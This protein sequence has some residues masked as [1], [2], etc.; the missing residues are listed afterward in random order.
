[1]FTIKFSRLKVFGATF[2]QKG[3]EKILSQTNYSINVNIKGFKSFF[4]FDLG[5]AVLDEAHC[6]EGEEYEDR[7][8]EEEALIADI[9][10]ERACYDGRNDLSRHTE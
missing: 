8:V 10:Y 6:Y 2:F 9:L 1:M 7:G 5:I 3:S 4:S